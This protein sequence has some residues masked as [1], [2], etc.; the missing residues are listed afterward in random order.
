MFSEYANITRTGRD[1]SRDRKTRCQ[2]PVTKKSFIIIYD[3][4]FVSKSLVHG[5]KAK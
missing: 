4:M 5:M 2:E 1:T 3:N